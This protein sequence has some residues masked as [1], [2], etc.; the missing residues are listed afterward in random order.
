MGGASLC[1]L[2]S[3]FSAQRLM[4]Q[5]CVVSVALLSSEYAPRHAMGLSLF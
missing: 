2:G 1:V 5:M 4:E 3:S